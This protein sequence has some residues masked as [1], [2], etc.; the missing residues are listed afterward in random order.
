MKGGIQKWMEEIMQKW[1]K[2]GILK[3]M[4]GE[5]VKQIGIGVW[6]KQ[7][8]EKGEEDTETE[9]EMERGY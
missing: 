9:S 4:K 3:W 8:M 2:G 6:G 1:M 7:V 5:G